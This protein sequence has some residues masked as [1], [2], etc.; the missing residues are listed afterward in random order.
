MGRDFARGEGLKVIRMDVDEERTSVVMQKHRCA[1]LGSLNVVGPTFSRRM[2]VV[3]SDVLSD[4]FAQFGSEAIDVDVFH[5]DSPFHLS[6][7]T[8]VLQNNRFTNQ[9]SFHKVQKECN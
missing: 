5:D 3:Q 2:D 8:F 4:E 7:Y 9:L 6:M 1:S